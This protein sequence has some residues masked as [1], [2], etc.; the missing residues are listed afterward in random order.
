MKGI[1][2]KGGIAA[3]LAEKERSKKDE[4]RKLEATAK[5]VEERHTERRLTY[6][7]NVVERFAKQTLDRQG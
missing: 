3:M 4:D 2:A 1:V 5:K 7:R 6:L